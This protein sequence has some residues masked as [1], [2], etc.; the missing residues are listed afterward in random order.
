MRP[1]QNPVWGWLY[2]FTAITVV[3]S[4]L[5]I[6]VFMVSTSLRVPGSIPPPVLQLIPDNPS[7]AA[8]T[9]AFNDL[10]LAR[11][12][13]NSAVIVG[14]AVPLTLVF[15]SWAGL[16]IAGMGRRG[17]RVW[18]YALVALMI[19]P[20][21]AFWLAR[22]VLFAQLGF[23]DTVWPLVAPALIGAN[24]LYVLILAWAFRRVPRE[25]WESARL[26]GAGTL[27]LWSEVGL[28]L[29]RPALGAVAVLAF[30]QFWGD[31]ISPAL[32]LRTDA[33]MTAPI[34]LQAL[35]QYDRTQWPVL[36]AAAVILMLP[37]V[38][39]FLWVQ[40]TAWNPGKIYEK[41]EL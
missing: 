27:V 19:F 38:L 28:P 31:F 20:A 13:F 41:V 3:G 16:A 11:Y 29:V 36:T 6:L 2:H 14:I 17:W 24:P 18:L 32:Y 10:P 12:L 5:L 8:Y 23:I 33:R 30:A 40:R 35:I 21:S 26:D 25:L 22:Y 9:R 34:A 4:G 37:S 39:L 7:L 1:R 15:A